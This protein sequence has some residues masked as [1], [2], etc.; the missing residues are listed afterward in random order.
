MT[1]IDHA[2]TTV[3]TLLSRDSTDPKT[4]RDLIVSLFH[5]DVTVEAIVSFLIA[6]SH[7]REKEDLPEKPTVEDL[8]GL[9]RSMRESSPENRDIWANRFKSGHAQYLCSDCGYAG[10]SDDFKSPDTGNIMCMTCGCFKDRRY[11]TQWSADEQAAFEAEQERLRLIRVARDKR[12]IEKRQRALELEPKVKEVLAALDGVG[13]FVNEAEEC[14]EIGP[15][16]RAVVHASTLTA[17]E[18]V[19]EWKQHAATHELIAKFT[20]LPVHEFAARVILGETS[21]KEILDQIDNYEPSELDPLEAGEERFL[22]TREEF[23]HEMTVNT[24]RWQSLMDTRDLGTGLGTDG[25]FAITVHAKGYAEAHPCLCAD[26]K[27]KRSID[28]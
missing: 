7:R 27:A 22:F 23:I 24:G 28:A 26:C 6:T 11:F 4:V 10:N 3:L 9:L 18:I 13:D 14:E 12:E 15:Y 25:R 17:D 19:S 20:R 8:R 2:V 21:M 1:T 5:E 16:V